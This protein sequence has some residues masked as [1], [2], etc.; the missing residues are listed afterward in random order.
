LDAKSKFDQNIQTSK[1]LI[2]SMLKQSE[3]D[4]WA[5]KWWYWN[6]PKIML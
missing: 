5:F 2:K 1:L 3:S 4:F 6:I